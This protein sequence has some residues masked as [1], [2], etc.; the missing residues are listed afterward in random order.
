MAPGCS[1]PG[2]TGRR[3]AGAR[4]GEPGSAG[5][6]RAHAHGASFPSAIQAVGTGRVALEDVGAVG[7]A[8]TLDTVGLAL[9]PRDPQERRPSIG[10]LVLPA[11]ARYLLLFRQGRGDPDPL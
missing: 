6:L 1:G 9:P 2:L 11:H 8:E 3:W 7:A 4:A 10:G 5:G